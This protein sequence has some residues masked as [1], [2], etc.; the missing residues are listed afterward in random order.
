MTTKMKKTEGTYRW[1]VWF[2]SS[3]FFSS[4]GTYSMNMHPFITNLISAWYSKP[5]RM[6]TKEGRGIH[7][8]NLISPCYLQTTTKMRKRRRRRRRRQRGTYRR[9]VWSPPAAW[10]DHHN[11]RGQIFAP[12][13][14]Q[15][16][17]P[18]AWRTGR[19]NGS[20]C[21]LP[22]WDIWVSSGRSQPGRKH[23]KSAMILMNKHWKQNHSRKHL[24]MWLKTF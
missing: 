8:Q 1:W 17:G 3:F 9:W 15:T 4:R 6:T 12:P 2:P 13:S 11:N 24:C 20:R 19:W 22:R 16:P 5:T 14:S 10:P 7:C 18:V 21:T 23:R